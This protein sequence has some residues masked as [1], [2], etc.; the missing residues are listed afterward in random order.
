MI[1]E[2]VE[3]GGVPELEPAAPADPGPVADLS[4]MTL[5]PT[6]TDPDVT[7][8]PSP[9][10]EPVWPRVGAVLSGSFDL[11]TQARTRL[12]NTS[13]YVGLLGLLSMGPA[14][15]VVLAAAPAFGQLLAAGDG[16]PT[17]RALAAS[18][19]PGWSVVSIYLVFVAVIAVG[20]EAQIL[21]VA[22]LGGVRSGRPLTVQ[23]AVRRSRAVFWRVFRVI[24]AVSL[25]TSS[26]GAALS[27]LFRT[28][29]GAGSETASVVPNLLV[30]I[31]SAPFVYV[32][33]GIVL[34]NVGA[35]EAL[36]RS[37]RLARARFRLAL[38][39][40][41]F[42]V[43]A[44]YLLLFG[45]FSA[46][47]IVRRMLVPFQGQ[48]NALDVT[49][50]PGFVVVGAGVLVA[51]FAYWTLSFTIGAM[52]AAPAV[53]AFLGLTGYSGGLDAA[54]DIEPGAPPRKPA[55]W[56]SRPMRL[57]IIIGLIGLTATMAAWPR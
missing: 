23:E 11:L 31:L 1:D 29:F 21:S 22:I 4:M 28:V 27:A 39:A 25:V 51:V 6:G 12:R 26:L 56:L 33:S 35:R 2:P 52:T 10:V 40:S 53:V 30:G 5:A 36:R 55:A 7:P 8:E 49:S 42:A 18:T 57:A 43:V 47:D 32:V 20:V 44:Q 16:G 24:V 34:G 46:A 45:A 15:L 3:P 14:I 13:L 48:L 9:V 19:L 37:V 54:R 50:R 41:V 17:A 38:L